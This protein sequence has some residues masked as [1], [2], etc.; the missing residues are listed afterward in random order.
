MPD[1]VPLQSNTVRS[2]SWAGDVN[3]DGYADAVIA[4]ITGMAI[5]H[6]SGE[7]YVVLGSAT[8]ITAATM[9]PNNGPGDVIGVTGA[10]DVNGD[11]VDDFAVAAGTYS[12]SFGPSAAFIL[13][14]SLTPISGNPALTFDEPGNYHFDGHLAAGCDYDGDGW[15]DIAFGLYGTSH[16]VQRY[17]NGRSGFQMQYLDNVLGYPGNVGAVGCGDLSGDGTDDTVF[18]TPTSTPGTA[19]IHV[20]AAPGIAATDANFSSVTS[21]ATL[22]SALAVI[23][24]YDDDGF[25]DIAFGGGT[26][27]LVYTRGASMAPYLVTGS[28]A[29]QTISTGSASFGLIVAL[30]DPRGP[31]WRELDAL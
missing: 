12:T 21:G 31:G 6:P 22:G 17:A 29:V 19:V 28:F 18:S 1:V 4:G 24:D 14:G 5:G 10:G 26:G 2:V 16:G 9:F 30:L 25:V 8:P 3:H 7:W 13:A 15:P 11:G 27:T 23:G 20:V